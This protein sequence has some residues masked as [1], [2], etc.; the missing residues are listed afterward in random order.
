MPLLDQNCVLGMERYRHIKRSVISVGTRKKPKW[1]LKF[2]KANVEC[3][4][5]ATNGKALDDETALRHIL[6]QV[7][8]S[9]FFRNASHIGEMNW[10]GFVSWHSKW[11]REICR[12]GLD[13]RRNLPDDDELRGDEDVCV[14]ATGL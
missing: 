14:L 11:S 3:P 12:Q 6:G 7:G 10:S 9:L 8:A 13:K 5:H 4:C 2:G 1:R